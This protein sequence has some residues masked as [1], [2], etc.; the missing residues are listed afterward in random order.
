MELVD[1]KLTETLSLESVPGVEVEVR[2]AVA[3]Q[4]FQAMGQLANI[5]EG[6][7]AEGLVTAIRMFGD[8]FIEAWNV[9]VKG[10]PLPV[11]GESLARLPL[12]MQLELTS[13]WFGLIRGPSGPLGNASS[14]QSDSLAPS[15]DEPGDG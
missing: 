4:D 8:K 6:A 10:E 7:D 2:L 13:R 12:A 5:G 11:S 14:T 15:T 1:I 3:F 9:S